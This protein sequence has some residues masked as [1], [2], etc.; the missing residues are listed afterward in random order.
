MSTKPPMTVQLAWQRDLVFDASAGGV[1]LTLDGDA[2]AGP[3]PMQAV[4]FGLAGCM[5]ADLVHILERG[6]HPLEA[7]NVRLVAHRA[8]AQPPRFTRMDLEY[9]VTGEVPAEAIQRALDLSRE[10]YCSVWHSL[11]QDIELNVT[12]VV[13]AG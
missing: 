1:D 5:A 7:L 13:A 12:F 11:R 4:A 10:K 9:T 8:A 6:R 2:K 3:S